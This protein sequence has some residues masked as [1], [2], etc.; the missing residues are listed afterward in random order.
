MKRRDSSAFAIVAVLAIGGCGST[1][2][3]SQPF[4]TGAGASIA[5]AASATPSTPATAGSSHSP[6][7]SSG[8]IAALDARLVDPIGLVFDAGGN[9]YVSDCSEPTDSSIFRID[10][11]WMLTTYAGL[12]QADFTGDGGPATAATL[13][14]PLG[15]AVGPDGTFY[16]ADHA[17]NRIRRI[18]G[19]GII[20][21]VAGSG[22][23]GV[24][25]GSY[26]GDGGPATKATLK[27]PFGLAFDALGNMFI[28]DRDN[29]R[30]RK[31]D[32]SGVITTIAGNGK[33]EPPRD[34]VMGTESSI[35]FPL[36]IIC[37][38]K[39]NVL[40]ADAN[41]KRIRRIDASGRITTIAGTGENRATGDGGPATKAA[42][43][44]PENM[45]F[46]AA[47]NLYI[48]DTVSNTLR[49]IDSN[50]VITT[51]ASKLGGNGLAIDSAGN[52]FVTQ[53]DSNGVFRIDTKGVVTRVVGKPG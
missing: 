28:S 37:D 10:P 29:N 39:G 3:S 20:T 22:S 17:N 9:L 23:A 50:G 44:D 18:D 35:D 42:L 32:P 45:A 31:V 47:G 30:I 34:G 4:A 14:C 43:A 7:A 25:Q 38:A 27:E 21:T 48:T 26:S 13:H 52:L 6:V 11:S 1:G 36:G 49:R 19:A 51:L 41:N 15:M 46:D 8:P 40:F 16:F 12:G 33:F 5:I 24:D 53:A 2:S